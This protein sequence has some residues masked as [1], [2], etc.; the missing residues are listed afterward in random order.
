ME[1]FQ[2]GGLNYIS[3]S[4]IIISNMFIIV[5]DFTLSIVITLKNVVLIHSV[6]PFGCINF[7]YVSVLKFFDGNC[8]YTVLHYKFL[9]FPQNFFCKI[10]Y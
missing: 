9:C 3:I 8:Y 2:K 10:T 5:V 4:I 7:L 6:I 1:S